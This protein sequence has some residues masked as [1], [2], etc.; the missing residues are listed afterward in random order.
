MERSWAFKRIGQQ[1][2]F[3][4]GEYSFEII[5]DVGCLLLVIGKNQEKGGFIFKQAGQEESELGS[6]DAVDF[7]FFA[8]N[9]YDLAYSLNGGIS[10]INIGNRV[11]WIHVL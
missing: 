2:D 5:L 9:G 4:G 3:I 10:L 8:G 6:N 7:D 1:E 11:G